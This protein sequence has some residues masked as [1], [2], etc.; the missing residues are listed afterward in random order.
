MVEGLKDRNRI[1]HRSYFQRMGGEIRKVRIGS[2]IHGAFREYPSHNLFH[3]NYPWDEL[4]ESIDKYGYDTDRF[5]YITVVEC[6]TCESERYTTRDGNHR[7]HTLK[8]M[9]GEEHFISVKV[10]KNYTLP[11]ARYFTLKKCGWCDKV[12]GLTKKTSGKLELLNIIIMST[13]FLLLYVKPTLMFMGFL[14]S[15]I[16]LSTTG[17]FDIKKETYNKIG[18]KYGGIMGALINVVKNLPM[19]AITIA[20]IYYIWV[21]ISISIYYFMLLVAFASIMGYLI[22]YYEKKEEGGR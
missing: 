17:V 3:T 6:S 11:W 16:I 19:I 20:S 8:G 21:L 1:K 12:R 15:T 13:A 2:V 5:G 4:R 14:L 7:L 22:S 10:V 18:Y 9:F